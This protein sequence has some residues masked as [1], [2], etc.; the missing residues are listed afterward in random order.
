MRIT[1][2][3]LFNL[4]AFLKSQMFLLPVLYLFYLSNGLT[5]AD[6]FLFQGMIV[7][8]NVFLQIPAGYVGDYLSRKYIVIIS[9]ILFLGRIVLWGFFSGGMIVFLGELLYAVSKALF[10]AIESPYLFDILEK[11]QK[12]YKMLK[13]YSRLNF[14]LSAGTSI[15]ALIGAWLYETAGLTI[16]LTTEFILV[17]CAVFIAIHLPNSQGTGYRHP[18]MSLHTFFQTFK[19]LFHTTLYRAFIA[20]SGL[21]VACSHFFFWSFQPLMKAASVPVILFGIVIF[22]NNLMRS[23]FSLYTEQ[24]LKII[25]LTRLGTLAFIMN[26]IGFLGAFLMGRMG[27][28]SAPIC[29]M[30]IF[31]LCCA[32]VVQL[33]FSIAHIARLQRLAPPAH[34]AQ[35]ASTNMM[36]AR[37]LSAVFLIVPKYGMSVIPLDGLFGIYA[38]VFCILG[39]CF[40]KEVR[41]VQEQ[42]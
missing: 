40:L 37:L 39:G 13:A 24:I 19:R 9:Y 21:L 12:S 11:R 16:L 32:I 33:M 36:I 25:S 42:A 3:T 7:L 23:T 27:I 8:M 20:Y 34:R 2:L 35:I 10:D 30:Y 28:V 5:P 6:Y 17:S 22:I 14:A 41:H 18:P 31:F 29:L 38:L 1:P 15:A 26:M 4:S